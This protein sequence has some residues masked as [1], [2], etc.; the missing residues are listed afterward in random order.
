MFKYLTLAATALTGLA[1]SSG[2]VAGKPKEAPQAPAASAPATDATPAA[3]E[4]KYCV[5]STPLGSHIRQKECRTRKQ[6]M[7]DGFDPL[8]P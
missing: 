2:A 7:A 5:V 6:W 8:N 3:K 4:T 1:M